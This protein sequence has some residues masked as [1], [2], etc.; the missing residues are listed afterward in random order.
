[1]GFVF[2][3]KFVVTLVLAGWWVS[4]FALRLVLDLI[5]FGVCGPGLGWVCA[6]SFASL[7]CGGCF[8]FV[9][10]V[11]VGDDWSDGFCW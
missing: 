2:C 1:M 7:G 4:W 6:L 5:G 8:S 11:A 3:V 9:G 10:L